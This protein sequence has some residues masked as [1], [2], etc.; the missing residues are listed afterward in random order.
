MIP[1]KINVKKR[2]KNLCLYAVL[3]EVISTEAA[4]EEPRA[5]LID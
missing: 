2:E 3:L 4:N 5:G 1:L